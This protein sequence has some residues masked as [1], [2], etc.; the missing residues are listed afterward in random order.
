MSF[1]D[2]IE[3]TKPANPNTN[4]WRLYFKT[5]GLYIIDDAGNEIGPLIKDAPS[6]GSQYARKNAAWEAVAGGGINPNI[7]PNGGFRVAQRGAGPFTS[8]STPFV[9]NDD[10]YLLDGCILLS[11]GNDIVDVSQIANTDFVSGKAIQL[12]V[13]T[14][15]K[16]FGVLFPIENADIQDVRKSGKASVQFKVKC[17]GTS[18]SNVRAY[19]LSWSSTADAITSDVI[20]AWGAAG[21]DPTLVA[22]WTAENTGANLAI[23]TT[24]A[25]KKI[26]NIAVDTAGVTN[27]ALLITLDDTDAS[28]GDFLIIGDVKVETGATCTDFM[29]STVAEMMQRC[30][31]L[32]TVFQ[33]D[34][35]Q[36]AIF[37]MG[38]WWSA[39]LAYV[40]IHFP[41]EMR[42]IPTLAYDALANFRIWD[43]PSDVLT[44]TAI[45]NSYGTKKLG[46]LGV[47]VAASGTDG[48]AAMLS[49][50][51][52][53]NSILIFSAEL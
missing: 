14:A 7:L 1:L 6:D 33:A 22:N 13:E 3:Q 36:W 46:G 48:N 12:D 32:C 25:L 38:V 19:L 43:S 5:D 24:V 37:G 16:K 40:A 30:Q 52:T 4:N 50:N 11:D 53:T 45:N 15:N 39:T 34:G 28:I 49:N 31:R 10:T 9:N 27:L 29:V 21:A 35:T 2:M 20:N 8:V 51:N 41:V 18:M 44:P 17:T 26:E 42:A 47:T 23:N